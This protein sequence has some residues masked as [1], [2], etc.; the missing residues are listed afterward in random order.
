[1]R[2]TFFQLC[3][4]G[5][6]ALLAVTLCINFV[7]AAEIYPSGSVNSG[8]ETGETPS[9]TIL[10]LI[11]KDSEGTHITSLGLWSIVGVGTLT[12]TGVI[13]VL[14]GGNTQLMG[15]WIFSA[16]FWASWTN[17]MVITEIGSWIPA[18]LI[19]IMT[20]L[21][22]PIFIGGLIGIFSGAG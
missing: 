17:L 6:L 9:D 18:G 3:I 21:A 14:T 22:V 11:E 8:V 7:S 1:M 4:I 15:G 12:I 20:V 2:E 19:L 10:D 13:A 16:I 5:T